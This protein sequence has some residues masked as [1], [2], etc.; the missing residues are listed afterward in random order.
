MQA[1]A[2]EVGNL[3]YAGDSTGDAPRRRR[4]FYFGRLTLYSLAGNFLPS[5]D[6]DGTTTFRV[7]VVLMAVWFA[8]LIYDTFT[9][10]V[11]KRLR[12][13]PYLVIT[14]LIGLSAWHFETRDIVMFGFLYTVFFAGAGLM[15]V[16]SDHFELH[17]IRLDE[18]GVEV[19]CSNAKAFNS[20]TRTERTRFAWSEILRSHIKTTDNEGN[21]AYV[22]EVVSAREVLGHNSFEISV[23]DEKDVGP[24]RDRL[25]Q[26]RAD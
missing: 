5:L 14:A 1:V 21:E 12:A 15:C 3:N 2:I 9:K 18:S 10:D 20:V 19:V 16:Y 4:A 25:N 11:R 6:R 24:M 22:L 8:V 17:G 7:A 23:K 26:L 13:V